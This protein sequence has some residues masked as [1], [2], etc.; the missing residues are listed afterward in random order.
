MVKSADPAMTIG[1]V[2]LLEKTGDA[3][4][5]GAI[6]KPPTSVPERP[7]AGSARSSEPFP[8]EGLPLKQAQVQILDALQPLGC[9][10]AVPGF[11]ASFMDGYAIAGDAPPEPGQLASCG[12]EQLRVWVRPR[13]WGC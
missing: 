5:Y 8:A 12:V 13:G 3:T 7:M 1:P 9:S 4:A 2:R 6:L 11:R 10:E